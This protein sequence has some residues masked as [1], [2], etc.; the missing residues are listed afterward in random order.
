[1]VVDDEITVQSAFKNTITRA[2][3]NGMSEKGLEESRGLFKE[4]RDIFRIK[5]GQIP[6]LRWIH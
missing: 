5:L 1:L 3:K 6:Q 2:K 4:F